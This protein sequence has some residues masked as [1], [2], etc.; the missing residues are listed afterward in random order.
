MTRGAIFHVVNGDSTLG[1]FQE[2]TVPGKAVVWPYMLMEG[3]LRAGHGGPARSSPFIDC[4]IFPDH[5]PLFPHRSPP[6]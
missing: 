4:R 6:K 2:S 1:L 5:C 3:P